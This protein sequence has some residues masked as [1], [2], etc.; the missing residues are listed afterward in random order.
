VS[1]VL[2]FC[3]GLVAARFVVLAGRDVLRAPVLQRPNFRDRTVPT[4]AGVLA[5]VAVLLVE[6]GRALVGVFGVGE[7]VPTTARTL[8]LLACVGFCLL[9]LLDDL[10]GTDRER[11][12]GGHLRALAAGRI[13]TGVMKMV[14]GA[15]LAIVLVAHERAGASATRV[16]ADAALVAL[17]AN[18]ANLFD[19]AP[20]RTIK[21]A[22]V[23][24]LPLALLAGT[25][26]VGVAIA[27]VAGAFAG[28]L[29]DDVRERLMLGD[30]GANA[31]GG[32]LGLAVVLECAPATRTVVLVVL[33][34]L[35]AVSEVVSFGRVID[36]VPPLRAFDR[37]GRPE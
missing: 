24:W 37:L 19:R 20:G 12:F 18:L 5:V 11:G 17:A 26:A 4:A 3:V 10:A 13:T 32:A 28:L 7:K 6:G 30:A 16:I 36:R 23:A 27:P 9:G 21:L 2:A 22:L 31:L 14:G 35:T 15:A 29:G 34:L 1:V 33:V 8:L 25:D